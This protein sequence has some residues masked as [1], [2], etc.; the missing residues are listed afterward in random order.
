[1]AIILLVIVLA[2]SS[3]IRTGFSLAHRYAL[4]WVVVKLG[5]YDVYLGVDWTREKIIRKA[6]KK[7]EAMKW[8]VKK[9]KQTRKAA[10][11][12][13]QKDEADKRAEADA[14]RA[15]ADEETERKKREAAEAAQGGSNGA[16]PVGPALAPGEQGPPASRNPSISR[17][18]VVIPP[19]PLVHGRR[20]DPR[21][22][23]STA[24]QTTDSLL[25]SMGR[26]SADNMV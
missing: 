23:P 20:A 9:A 5:I 11:L 17:G 14:K 21:P 12:A 16:V 25:P 6:E 26:M 10:A 18:T 1:M 19:V 4:T 15:K 7:V 13:R 3:L 24:T 2:Y 22:R 8:K